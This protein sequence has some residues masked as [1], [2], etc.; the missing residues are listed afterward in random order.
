L[1]VQRKLGVAA[2]ASARISIFDGAEQPVWVSAGDVDDAD[3]V[4]SRHDISALADNQSAVQIGF[5]VMAG[6]AG[7]SYGWNIDELIVKDATQPDYLTCGGCSDEPAFAGIGAVHDAE[8]CGASGLTIE[9]EPAP[10]WGGGSSGT[11]EVHR[12]AT[13]DF[14]PGAGN[15]VADGLTSTTWVDTNA[16][17]DSE[18]WYVVRA[19][20]DESCAGGEGISETNLVRLSS[21]ET[22]SQSPPVSVG[23]S[24]RA[25][26][27][28]GAHVRLSWD[29][30]P[31]ADHYIIRRSDSND[32]SA[33]TD[34]GSTSA[35]FFEDP[36]AAA[37]ENFYSYRVFTV[38]ACGEEAE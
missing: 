37:N 36:N 33:V 29:A 4:E 15:L 2:S 16:P 38:N 18:V 21:T 31:G 9:W 34:I 8:P 11:Y 13:P 3:W 32:F 17:V 14:V 5:G 24:V 20:N 6:F 22:V 28:G 12:G 25:L 1:I 23:G 7:Q 26:R 30:M 35:T 10:A 19:R 27:V